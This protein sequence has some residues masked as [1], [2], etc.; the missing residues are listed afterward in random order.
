M[1]KTPV[2]LSVGKIGPDGQNNIAFKVR[3]VASFS[4][5]F[6][7]SIDADGQVTE[8]PRGGQIS[9]RVKALNDGNNELACWM[10][11]PKMQ[12]DGTIIFW[13]TRTSNIMKILSFK[14]AYCI[15]YIEH[16]QDTIH[17]DILAHY[18][19]ITIS[20]REI[21]ASKMIFTNNWDLEINT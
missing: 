2:S 11:D 21:T 9:M 13:D 7:Q 14:D 16:W 3:E 18:E 8:V 10:V 19:D 17:D 12:M 4:M 20:C 5:S 1:A 15:N 6:Y